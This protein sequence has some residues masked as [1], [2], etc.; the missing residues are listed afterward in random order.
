MLCG[1]ESTSL[2]PL[3]FKF[4]ICAG[5]C[6]LSLHFPFLPPYFSC[7]NL[8][9]CRHGK[10]LLWI[11]WVFIFAW[12]VDFCPGLLPMLHTVLWERSSCSLWPLTISLPFSLHSCG[13]VPWAE[14]LALLPHLQCAVLLHSSIQCWKSMGTMWTTHWIVST[15]RYFNIDGLFLSIVCRHAAS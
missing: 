10:L 7:W 8:L 13:L 5:L 1:L 3:N 9:S 14:H 4:Q 2:L 11:F 15:V 6:C 12:N